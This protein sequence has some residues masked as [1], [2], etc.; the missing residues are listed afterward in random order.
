MGRKLTLVAR[1]YY[2]GSVVLRRVGFGCRT[3]TSTS[4]RDLSVGRAFDH[5]RLVTV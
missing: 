4:I 5:L 2:Y 1:A 3:Q